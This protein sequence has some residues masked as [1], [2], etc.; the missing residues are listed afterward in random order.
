MKTAPI[1][2]LFLR[3]GRI[4]TDHSHY[5]CKGRSPAPQ[6]GLSC[7]CGA[8]YLLAISRWKVATSIVSKL[9]TA[10]LPPAFMRG[11]P[12]GR[13]ESCRTAN[14]PKGFSR[15]DPVPHTPPCPALRLDIPPHKCGG[16]GVRWF[17]QHS[18]TSHP[19]RG[20][21]EEGLPVK[22]PWKDRRLARFGD[23]HQ[24][25]ISGS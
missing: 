23:G 2:G 8:I 18:A 12:E 15:S 9:S 10:P 1:R 13:G 17:S 20:S 6:G 4:R 21:Q 5:H 24:Q 14:S 3:F 16:Q 7:P 25:H 11:V 22:I 19:R